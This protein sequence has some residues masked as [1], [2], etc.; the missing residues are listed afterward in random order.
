V[1]GLAEFIREGYEAMNRRD[2]DAALARMRPDVVWENDSGGPE[3]ATR[4]VGR[5]EVLGFW[6]EFFGVWD[7]YRFELLEVVEAGPDLAVARTLLKTWMRGADEPVSMQTSYVWTI[8]DDEACHVGL[9][10]NHGD[11][12]KAAGLSE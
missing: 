10:F 9:Y 11:A 5:E 2:F 12:L 8:R 6:K 7:R 3:G 4:Y 1:Q